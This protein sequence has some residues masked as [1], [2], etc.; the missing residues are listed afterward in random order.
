MIVV[1]GSANMDR[2]IYVDNFPQIG[3]TR[4]ASYEVMHSGGKGAN[5]A[6][7]ARKIGSEVYFFGSVGQDK[8]GNMLLENFQT[9]GIDVSGVNV[10]TSRLSGVAYITVNSVADNTIVYVPGA[11]TEVKASQI[12]DYF[13]TPQTT[14]LL[15]MEISPSENWKLI[16]R[17]K[18]RGSKV[19]LNAA[20]LTHVPE[21]IISEI[22]VLVMNTTEAHMLADSIGIE[23]DDFEDIAKTIVAR[24]HNICIITLGKNGVLAV[25]P[26]DYINLPAIDVTA[27]DTTSAGDALIATF[28]TYYDQGY[29][30]K[31]CLMAGNIAGGLATTRCGAQESLPTAEEVKTVLKALTEEERNLC[32]L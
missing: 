13:L 29:P 23:Y 31:T 27:I 24:F 15:Q 19:I 2:M 4:I 11:N 9:Y 3:E 10:S 1:L 30:L 25:T 28:A 22:D 5:Q 32:C 17:A 20:P 7:C 21:E 26:N 12:P 6:I 8:A 16:H 18:D 14:V